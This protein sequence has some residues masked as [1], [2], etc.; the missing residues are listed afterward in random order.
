MNVTEEEAD[1]LLLTLDPLAAM[2]EPDSR[3]IQRLL[4]TVRTDNEAVDHL[5]RL[6]AGERLWQIAHPDELHL[7]EIPLKEPMSFEK[8][9]AQKWARF[10][11]P[12]TIGSRVQIV[13]MGSR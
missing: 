2:A 8:N 7:A 9:G 5:I 12:A 1:K 4:E 6:T 11:A 3:Q 10:G 13:R